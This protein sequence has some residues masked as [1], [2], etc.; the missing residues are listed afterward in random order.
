MGCPSLTSCSG[1]SPRTPWQKVPL[2]THRALAQRGCPLASGGRRAWFVIAQLCDCGCRCAV[3]A[4][5]SVT[6]RGLH[7]RLSLARFSRLS[8]SRIHTPAVCWLSGLLSC[9]PSSWPAC[10]SVVSA[11]MQVPCV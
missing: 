4:A 6:Q 1:E 2:V 8:P 9:W 7:G 10:L 5:A 11:G 3:R